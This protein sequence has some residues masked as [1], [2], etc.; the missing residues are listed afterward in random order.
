[1]CPT[2]W[3]EVILDCIYSLN[4][5]HLP[6]EVSVLS[7]PKI[8]ASHSDSDGDILP[9]AGTADHTASKTCRLGR[10]VFEMVKSPNHLS[11]GTGIWG[12]HKEEENEVWVQSWEITVNREG[13]LVLVAVMGYWSWSYGLTPAVSVQWKKIVSLE[14]WIWIGAINHQRTKGTLAVIQLRNYFI[15]RVIIPVCI[16]S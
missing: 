2:G 6:M 16:L 3:A 12:Q 13:Q 15:R 8:L 1:M 14:P 7:C 5:H 11:T 10:R 4:Q 9:C